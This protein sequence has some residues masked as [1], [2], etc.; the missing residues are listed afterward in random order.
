MKVL[1]KI[2]LSRHLIVEVEGRTSGTDTEYLYCSHVRVHDGVVNELVAEFKRYNL[3]KRNIFTG[4]EGTVSTFDDIILNTI[5]LTHEDITLFYR[6]NGET[7]DF[8]QTYAS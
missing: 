4:E 1:D 3:I 7:H 5:K 8:V 6:E 2:D